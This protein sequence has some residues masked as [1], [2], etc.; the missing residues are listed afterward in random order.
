[1][2]K[3]YY[4][5]HIHTGSMSIFETNEYNGIGGYDTKHEAI[6]ASINM[7]QKMQTNYNTE[8][9]N[10]TKQLLNISANLN[11]IHKAIIEL[12]NK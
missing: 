11:E 12:G 5:W 3:W 6:D 4:R 1:M 2:N 8:L 10:A 9:S 7:L